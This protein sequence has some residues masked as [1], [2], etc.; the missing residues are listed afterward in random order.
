MELDEL[1]AS[2]QQL[3]RRVQELTLI[4]RRLLIDSSVR[5]A[6]S[7]LAPLVAGAVAYMVIGALLA[8]LS[9]K[10][11]LVRPDSPG[12]LV[13]GIATLAW[14]IVFI[15]GGAGRLLLARRVDFTRPVVA[16]QR[17]LA[18]MQ[19]WE[20]WSFHAMWVVTSLLAVAILFGLAIA[21]A[22]DRFWEFWERAAGFFLPQLVFWLAA[23]VGPLLLYVWSRRRGGRVA[24]HMDRFLTNER[25]ARARA[26]IDEVE[27]FARD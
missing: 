19:R 21:T 13:M 22:G 4:N 16:I 9:V 7:L 8:A 11:M 20:A 15:V 24:A 27:E 17:S 26:A 2:W 1:K 14:G 5:K 3:D 6:R 23:A 12:A 18:S 25:I 10:A